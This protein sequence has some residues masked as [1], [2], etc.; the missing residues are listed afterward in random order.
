MKKLSIVL[1]LALLCAGVVHA[2]DRPVIRLG[3]RVFTEQT[4][5]A[6]I[7]A[8]YLGS[9]GYDVR[10]T[11]GLGSNLARS[12]QESGQLDMLWEYTGVSLVSYNHIDEKLDSAATYARVKQLDAQ[13]GLVWLTPSRFSNTYALALPEEVAKAYPQVNTIS[14]LNQVLIDEPKKGHILA[15]DTEFANRSD[16]LVGLTQ[17]YDL[18]FTRRDIRQMDAGLVYTALRNGQ[19]FTGLVYTTD[20]RLNAFKLKLLEDDLEYFPDYT[21][22]P[23]VRQQLLDA[24]PQLAA[25][26][27][28]LAEMLDDATMRELNAQ[29]DVEHRSP[30]V[31]AAEFLKAHPITDQAQEKP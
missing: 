24:H 21:A 14:Q 23:V 11:G 5:L 16:G 9:K 8:Q 13:K 25:Q 10:V 18:K 20:G 19:V 22:A 31:V 6:A 3:A 4:V 2:A 30:T 7:T 26:L 15:L 17:T 27:K 1:G 12:A 28:P 29:V